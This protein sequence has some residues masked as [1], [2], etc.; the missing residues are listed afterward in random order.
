MKRGLLG[1][2]LVCA[3]VSGWAWL[4]VDGSMVVAPA[5]ASPAP[6]QAML[7][8]VS[9]EDSGAVMREPQALP[10]A[11]TLLG[12]LLPAAADAANAEAPSLSPEA[13]E[14]IARSYFRA[15]VD[16]EELERALPAESES[17]PR[18]PER[19]PGYFAA[20]ARRD[21]L[22]MQLTQIQPPGPEEALPILDLRAEGRHFERAYRNWSREDLLVEHWR[23]SRAAHAESFRLL[24]DRLK[25]GPYEAKALEQSFALG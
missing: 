17:D 21:E 6:A 8:S 7:A 14:R 11:E 2:S 12:P 19:F 10:P 16:V 13:A 3:A 23:I 25:N 1:A 15:F 18:T 20:R 9:L 22:S 5:L 4:Q 24:A